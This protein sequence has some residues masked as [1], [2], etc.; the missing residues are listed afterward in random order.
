LSDPG[1]FALSCGGMVIHGGVWCGKGF[2]AAGELRFI[3]AELRA[4]LSLRYAT[5]SNPGRDAIKLDRASLG[6]FHG[7]GLT[8]KGG[9]ISLIGTRVTG[10]LNLERARLGEDGDVDDETAIWLEGATIGGI[11][12]MTWLRTAGEVRIRNSVIHGRVLLMHS[13]LEATDEVALRFT[14]NEVDTDVV[15][16]D[17][18]SIGETRFVDSRIGRHLDM[19]QVCLVNPGGV[20]LDARM[21]RA[22]EVSLVPGQ[23]VQGSVVLEHARIG[24]LRDDPAAWPDQMRLDGLVYEALLP[25]LPARRRLEWLASDAYGYQPQPYE[26]L[27]AHYTKIGQPVEAR[28][29]LHTREHRQRRTKPFLGRLWSVLQDV[30]VAY[31][32][33]PWR[34]LMWLAVLLIVGA[35]TFGISR[36]AALVSGAA[37]H[38]NPVIYTLDLLLPIVDL[39]QEHAFD[40]EGAAQWFSYFLI[41]AGWILAT[42]IAAGVARTLSRR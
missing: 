29:V 4:T 39:G 41:A 16:H 19:D 12:R 18:V 8:V 3:G 5:L 40:P 34:P 27:A 36:P 10:H 13:W 31:G 38:F 37:P 33:Q 28:R 11:L 21:L 22:A 42:T 17:L 23:A 20:A 32:Y 25:A 24:L 30:T 35:V 14:R 15:C 1:R 9:Q 6:E 2:T 7:A 26:Q